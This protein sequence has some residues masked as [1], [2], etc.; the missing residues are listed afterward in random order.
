MRPTRLPEQLS[1]KH[2]STVKNSTVP[3]IYANKTV[4]FQVFL[5]KNVRLNFSL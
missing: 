2:R 5:E 3:D 1:N 4:N